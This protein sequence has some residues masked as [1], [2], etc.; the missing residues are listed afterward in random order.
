M[1]NLLDTGEV[2]T[3]IGTLDCTPGL[4]HNFLITE[5]LSACIDASIYQQLVENIGQS[6]AVLCAL[7]WGDRISIRVISSTSDLEAVS[8][9]VP[10]RIPYAARIAMGFPI[11]PP[12]FYIGQNVDIEREING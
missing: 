10:D 3:A 1:M 5:V 8:Q 7:K 6:S 12:Q 11:E 2:Y 4:F 9:I